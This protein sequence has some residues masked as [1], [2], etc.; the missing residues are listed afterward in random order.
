MSSGA[1][2]DPQI[3]PQPQR[4]PFGDG[5]ITLQRG[6]TRQ[7]KQ[8]KKETV[9]DESRWQWMSDFRFFFMEI[10]SAS[11]DYAHSAA[12]TAFGASRMR[13][14]EQARERVSDGAVGRTLRVT[15]SRVD[16]SIQIRAREWVQRYVR[17]PH[18]FAS[19]SVSHSLSPSEGSSKDSSSG[20]H[21]RTLDG[22]NVVGATSQ[23]TG[24]AAS[25]ESTDETS[26]SCSKGVYNHISF[27]ASMAGNLPR[28]EGSSTT[29][30]V[31]M[32]YFVEEDDAG[33][34]GTANSTD[35][36][37]PNEA[38]TPVV[39]VSSS[40][41]AVWDDSELYRF[42]NS[43]GENIMN[44]RIFEYDGGRYDDDSTTD[45]A[46]KDD[47]LWEYQSITSVK[48]YYELYGEGK[49]CWFVQSM[50]EDAVVDGMQ[51]DPNTVYFEWCVKI[52]CRKGDE[53][54]VANTQWAW[55]LLLSLFLFPTALCACCVCCMSQGG[56]A[57][58]NRR[59]HFRISRS[60]RSNEG[61][62]GWLTRSIRNLRFRVHHVIFSQLSPDE[63]R[64]DGNETRGQRRGRNLGARE[65][66][67]TEI[68]SHRN[69]IHLVSSRKFSD[70]SDG[71]KGFREQVCAICI[72]DFE[73]ED[74]VKVLPCGH[75]FHSSCIDPWGEQSSLCPLCKTEV[76]NKVAAL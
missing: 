30:Y 50:S 66:E 13:E 4:A 49:T 39:A 58:R 31:A 70:I 60:S 8:S 61:G 55:I 27:S 46:V 71:E 56:L 22:T 59:H 65:Q 28:P 74:E 73:K 48:K 9:K 68:Q 45:D 57:P 69:Q 23:A 11:F 6:N 16:K 44:F 25:S 17:L 14:E 19:S 33:D 76:E 21:P 34:D 3:Q 63:D 53:C 29:V 5:G 62:D 15:R 2:Y 1:L 67:M 35:E 43:C 24:L 41:N 7:S 51:I 26:V 40:G 36:S 42:P 20:Y 18:I 47:L 12:L 32:H 10:S 52:R 37:T 75:V 64:E 54:Y 38:V 72:A